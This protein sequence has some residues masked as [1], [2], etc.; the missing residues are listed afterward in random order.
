MY[1][2]CDSLTEKTGFL[3]TVLYWSPILNDPNISAAYQNFLITI[4]MLFA[5]ILLRF[6][7]PYG[8]YME[9]RKDGMGRGGPVKSVAN[10]FRNTLNPGK[11]GREG[12][13]EGGVKVV[14]AI[15]SNSIG[16]VDYCSNTQRCVVRVLLVL[17]ASGAQCECDTLDILLSLSVRSVPILSLLLSQG[18]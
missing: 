11:G 7:F 1:I 17:L 18:T 14:V 15:V 5:A 3:L 2:Y 4:E 6:A 16:G 8:L 13:R 9:L 12:G 10:N